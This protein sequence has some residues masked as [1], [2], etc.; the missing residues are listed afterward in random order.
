MG[1]TTAA[2]LTTE[3][4]EISYRLLDHGLR[5]VSARIDDRRDAE[6]MFCLVDDA[7]GRIHAAP[8]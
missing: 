1:R 7:A 6:I 5:I 8:V 4:A 2:P 3:D